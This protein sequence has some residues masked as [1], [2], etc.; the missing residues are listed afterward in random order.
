[1]SHNKHTQAP[2][3]AS[4]PTFR[5]LDLIMPCSPAHP[6]Y[7]PPP[8]ALHGGGLGAADFSSTCH[9]SVCT[10]RLD[11][12]GNNLKRMATKYMQATKDRW[13]ELGSLCTEKIMKRSGFIGTLARGQPQSLVTVK[14]TVAQQGGGTAREFLRLLTSGFMLGSWGTRSVSYGEIGQYHP[15]GVKLHTECTWIPVFYEFQ[16]LEHLN[17]S[18]SLVAGW[19]C[20]GLYQFLF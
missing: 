6:V 18:F 1:M 16:A 13:T 4:T 5:D 2:N 9:Y 17:F 19:E 12:G 3:P 10:S 20:T 7:H 11:N 8:P 14:Q 15:G